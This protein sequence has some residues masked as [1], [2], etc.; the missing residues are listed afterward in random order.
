MNYKLLFFYQGSISELFLLLFAENLIL[1]ILAVLMGAML[2]KTLGKKFEMPDKREQ[3]YFGLTVII[4]TFVTYLGFLLWNYGLIHIHLTLDFSVLTDFIFTVLLM[5]LLVWLLHFI[6]H[7]KPFFE[8]IH[9]VSHISKKINPASLFVIHPIECLMLGFLWLSVLLVFT[10]NI[11]SI[12]L[13]LVFHVILGIIANLGTSIPSSGN[14]FLSVFISPA[15]RME[16]CKRGSGNFGFYT[17][18]WDNLF[19]TLSA[20]RTNFAKDTL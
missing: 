5:D 17:K 4:N 13:F 18:V 16:H 20:R 1:A 12:I 6:L 11:F 7:K 10:L 15:F 14:H 9:Y 19:K 8:K 3:K 2:L